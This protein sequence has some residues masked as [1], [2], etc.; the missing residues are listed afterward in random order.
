MIGQ[1]ILSVLDNFISC[2]L[3]FTEWHSAT[4]EHGSIED[5][6]H[7]WLDTVTFHDYGSDE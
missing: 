5:G 1:H 6:S 4:A 3:Y 7:E 2:S